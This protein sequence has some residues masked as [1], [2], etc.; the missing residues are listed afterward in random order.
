M[1]VLNF[2]FWYENVLRQ[3]VV[4]AYIVLE[5]VHPPLPDIDGSRDE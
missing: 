4:F 2:V 1:F 3:W 5:I